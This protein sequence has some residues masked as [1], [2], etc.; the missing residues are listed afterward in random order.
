MQVI[1]TNK[2]L[3]ILVNGYRSY[4]DGRYSFEHECLLKV[5]KEL[6]IHINQD[7][8][9]EEIY[10]RSSIRNKRYKQAKRDPWVEWQ[11]EVTDDAEKHLDRSLDGEDGEDM[12][13]YPC[14]T[15]Y[16]SDVMNDKFIYTI[17]HRH[18]AVMLYKWIKKW[19]PTRTDLKITRIK[20]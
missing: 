18:N 6:G 14:Y 17:P 7:V 16:E 3:T 8:I 19:H 13:P 15:K 11:F 20:H 2:F 1:D 5:L 9:D 10:R 4:S 12:V